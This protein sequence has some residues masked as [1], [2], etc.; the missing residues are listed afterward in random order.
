[1][2]IADAVGAATAISLAGLVFTATGPA[3]ELAP[4]VAALTLTTALA[5]GARAGLAA[6]VGLRGQTPNAATNTSTSMVG[7]TGRARW[8]AGAGR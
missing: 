5:V 2:S 3:S 4:F 6:Y 8:P 1:M 7:A